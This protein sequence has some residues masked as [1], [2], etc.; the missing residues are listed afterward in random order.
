M[1]WQFYENIKQVIRCVQI[2][3]SHHLFSIVLRFLNCSF[4]FVFAAQRHYWGR[5][6]ITNKYILFSCSRLSE[7][8]CLAYVYIISDFITSCNRV[9][10]NSLTQY[11]KH[12]WVHRTFKFL[13]PL[14]KK[15]KVIFC[16]F[17]TVALVFFLIYFSHDTIF[18]YGYLEEKF[19]NKFNAPNGKDD[20]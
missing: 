9:M 20:C 17:Y 18:L 4:Y 11:R 6:A 7:R 16:G 2:K 3:S 14:P 15:P 19:E 5:N 10:L 1:I 12:R 13:A 8:H